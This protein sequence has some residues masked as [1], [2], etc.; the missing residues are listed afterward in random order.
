MNAQS[1]AKPP[2]RRAFLMLFRGGVANALAQLA[3]SAVPDAAPNAAQRARVRAENLAKAQ[4]AR[5]SNA[6]V[7]ET[8]LPLTHCAR[9]YAEFAAAESETLCPDCRA[10][11]TKHQS[12][13][14]GLAAPA[15]AA[16]Q[17]GD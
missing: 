13:L 5:V 10:A 6:R 7:T 1:D 12:L 14:A 15:H 16:R 2:S 9:C 17:K 11:E 3:A 4:A 8:A